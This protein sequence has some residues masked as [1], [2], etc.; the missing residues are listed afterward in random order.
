[1]T[2]ES[3]IY[4]RKR[5]VEDYSALWQIFNVTVFCKQ[6]FYVASVLYFKIRHCLVYLT[7]LILS[8]FISL[9]FLPFISIFSVTSK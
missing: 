2:N 7:C 1:M 8:E 9:L 4:Q 5:V 6:I 3:L